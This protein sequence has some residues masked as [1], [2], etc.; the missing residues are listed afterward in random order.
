MK[1][2][3]AG[4]LV[5]AALSASAAVHATSYEALSANFAILV[6]GSEWR[7][8]KPAVTIDGSAY[9]PLKALGDALGV[10][11]IWNEELFQVE[12]SKPDPEAAKT[13]KTVTVDKTDAARPV[14]TIR[15]GSGRE[16][17]VELYP[18][19]APLTVGNFV[20]L[21][22]EGFY[23]G[24]TFHR[25]EP[26]FVI[27]GGD[28]LGNGTGGSGEKI[29]GEFD[30]NGVPNDLKHVTGTIS[31]ARSADPD[32]ASSQFFIMLGDAPHLDGNYAAFGKVTDGMDAVYEIAGSK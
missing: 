22:E 16:I 27:Q 8:D 29:K 19:K 3:I 9:L 24:L 12:I 2:F 13:M 32:S 14:V 25:I 20:K 17:K 26:G 5:G 31:M 6:N 15:T 7:G 10:D 4:V 1:K 21:A 28:P 11:V 18:D 30:S 23:D